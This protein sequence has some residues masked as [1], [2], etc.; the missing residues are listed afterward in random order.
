MT[1]AMTIALDTSGLISKLRKMTN[2]TPKE[3]KQ[4]ISDVSFKVEG[5]AKYAIQTGGRTGRIYKRGTKTHQASA[6]G[7]FPK[8]DTGE[9]VSNITSE[10]SSMGLEVTVGSRRSAPHGFMLEFGTSKMA[11]RP[12]LMPTIYSNRDYINKRFEKSLKDISRYFL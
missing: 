11:P 1:I 9:L 8:T 6:G 5:D 4:A 2:E 12:W 10:F 7:E 3:A